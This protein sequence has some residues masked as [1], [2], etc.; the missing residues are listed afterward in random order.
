MRHGV[1]RTKAPHASLRLRHG[2]GGHPTRIDHLTGAGALTHI[3]DV[4]SGTEVAARFFVEASI[5]FTAPHEPP[6]PPHGGRKGAMRSASGKRPATDVIL[7]APH[8]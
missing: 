7:G 1:T 4:I 6:P 3:D 2:H 8:G 5:D